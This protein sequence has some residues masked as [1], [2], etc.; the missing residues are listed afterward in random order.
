MH[1]RLF[2]RLKA[3]FGPQARVRLL[4]SSEDDELARYFDSV[5]ALG[6][7]DIDTDG[8]IYVKVHD[9][10]SAATK[11]CLLEE[12]AH[13]LQFLR[14]GAIELSADSPERDRRE[15]EVAECLLRRPR[16]LTHE[17]RAHYERVEQQLRNVI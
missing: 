15:Y 1:R 9:A 7:A 17:D 5:A 13:A 8:T 10:A 16:W 11:A 14:D 12:C 3:R 4:L 6:S 2:E